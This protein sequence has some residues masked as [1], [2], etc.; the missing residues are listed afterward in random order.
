M[1]SP[2]DF[3]Y[4][5]TSGHADLEALQLFAS[6]LKPRTL[7]PVHTEHKDDFKEHFDNVVV[8]EDGEEFSVNTPFRQA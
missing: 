2:N 6:A 7:I 4:A 5:H 1:Q 8:V 3:V